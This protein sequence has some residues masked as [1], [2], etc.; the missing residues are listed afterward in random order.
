MPRLFSTLM[1]RLP[2]R[3]EDPPPRQPGPSQPPSPDARALCEGLFDAAYYL[4]RN[5]DVAAAGLEPLA[6]F[7][8]YG[9][10]ELRDPNPL[11]DCAFYVRQCPEVVQAGENPL[12]HYVTRGAA[13]GYDPSPLFSTS[14]YMET[15]PDVVAVGMNPLAHFLLYG[16]REG[17]RS[18]S[19][20]RLSQR[21]Q[22]LMK[23]G[24]T[25]DARDVFALTVPHPPL[26]EG[27]AVTVAVRLRSAREALRERGGLV[28]DRLAGSVS[29]DAPVLHGASFQPPGGTAPLPPEYVGVLE[30][31]SVV[32]GTRLIIDVD[33]QLLHDELAQVPHPGEY[34]VKTR[35]E[36]PHVHGDRA[37]L[38][39]RRRPGDRIDTGVL[40]SC[41]HDYNYFHW[42]VECLPKLVFLN[43]LPEFEGL[44]LLIRKNLHPNLL[45]ALDV[46][47]QGR[48]P[49]IPLD[50]GH[51]FQVRRLVLP[52]DLSRLLDRYEGTPQV[53]TDC[54]LS[55]SWVKRTAELLAASRPGGAEKPWRKLYLTRRG[56][57]QRNVRNESA[58]E[59]ELLDRGFEVVQLDGASFESQVTLFRQAAVV[60]A[61]TGAALTNLLF[62]QP[63]TRVIVLTSN[64]ES[65]NF[66]VF[67]Q[68]ARIMDVRLEY[69]LGRRMYNLASF[70]VHDD[71]V[72]DVE[73]LLQVISGL[74]G[75]SADVAS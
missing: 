37:L 46:I 59:L 55:P 69:V 3:P 29:I 54:V 39:V 33:N 36:L 23:E 70:T 20:I 6:H 14:F 66:H 38:N 27:Q 56:A 28:V 53:E 25:R 57:A 41:D 40:L 9:G 32:G 47:N 64:H 31:V 63:G 61:P 44:P 15:Y 72:I 2:K 7:L 71:Y 12:L 5:P 45:R 13:Q 16:A 1:S 48:R 30:D 52:S 60:V 62:C 49:V 34:G 51:L 19:P 67:S 26:S 4:E 35:N 43:T 75:N 18:G 21:V 17:R 50:E 65:L 24:R 8:E 10:R 73:P 22:A 58:I 74:G 42:L 68:L 11:F